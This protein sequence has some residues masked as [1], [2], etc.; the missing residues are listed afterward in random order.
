MASRS[1]LIKLNGGMKA[2]SSAAINSTRAS[3]LIVSNF[4]KTSRLGAL[5]AS[6]NQ[7]CAHS[8]KSLFSDKKSGLFLNNNPSSSSQ[9]ASIHLTAKYLS[10]N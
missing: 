10:K 9:C 1:L 8:T 5:S 7:V 4:N 3:N 2:A 6:G